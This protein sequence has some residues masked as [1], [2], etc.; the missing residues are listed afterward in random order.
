LALP[1][2]ATEAYEALRRE[3]LRP[4]GQIVHS[5][6]RGVLIRCGFAKWAQSHPMFAAPPPPSPPQRRGQ[7][8]PAIAPGVE[9]ELVKLVAALILN[10]RQEVRHA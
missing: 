3:V 5:E 9:T 2:T 10:T 6:G 1:T 8:E 7:P 4:D